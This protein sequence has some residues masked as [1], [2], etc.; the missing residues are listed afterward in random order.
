MKSNNLEELILAWHKSGKSYVGKDTDIR[1][2]RINYISDDEA[3]YTLDYGNAFYYRDDFTICVT[4][5]ILWYTNERIRLLTSWTPV[6]QSL[7][8]DDDH[9]I[10]CDENGG[11]FSGRGSVLKH[12]LNQPEPTHGKTTRY[13]HWQ[14]MPEA[15]L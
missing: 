15:P 9:I 12:N 4:D 7:P 13:T 2:A 10:M 11:R 6:T 14:L 5:L 8:Q 1:V 3:S